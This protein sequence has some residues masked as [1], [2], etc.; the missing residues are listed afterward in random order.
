MPETVP[1]SER[2]ADGMGA[3]IFADILCAI[4]GKEG[5][6]SAM[7]QAVMLAG[8]QGRVTSLLVTSYRSAG[9]YR[10][11]AIGPTQAAEI[12]E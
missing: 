6:F 3:P 5:G 10:A 8:P 12:L 4:D 9:S 11:P 1:T 7:E 2:S